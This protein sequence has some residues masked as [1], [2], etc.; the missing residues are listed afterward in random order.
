MRVAII[1]ARGGSKRIPRKNIKPFCGKPIIAYSIEAALESG[2]FDK[3]VVS[4]DDPDIAN[5]ARQYGAEVPGLRSAANSDDYAPIVD[6]ILEVVESLER[7]G[8]SPEYLCC[9][10]ATAPFVTGEKIASA[11]SRLVE[12]NFSAVFPV[13]EFSYPIQ[14]SLEFKEDGSVG[15][16]WPENLLA[17]SQDLPK[18]YHDSGQYYWVVTEAMKRENTLFTR[19]SSGIVISQREAQDVDTLDDWLMAETKYKA[20]MYVEDTH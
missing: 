13:M 6:V 14:R 8:E 4:T 12:G 18:R 3:V 16:V 17:R 9:I 11:Y 19:N 1:P 2:C 7:V 15:M 10:F 20:L 5:I